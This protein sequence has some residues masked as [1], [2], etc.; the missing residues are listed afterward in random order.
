MTLKYKIYRLIYR[1]VNDLKINDSINNISMKEFNQLLMNKKN[2]K[3]LSK[4][5]LIEKLLKLDDRLTKLEKSIKK[6]NPKVS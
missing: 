3:K 2:L 1:M 4:S 6:T 5:Q